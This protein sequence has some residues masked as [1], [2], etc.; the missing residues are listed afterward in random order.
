MNKLFAALTKPAKLI[1]IIGGFVYALWF[2][3]HTGLSINGGFVN[4]FSNII[5]LFV[6][7]GLLVIPPLFLLIKKEETAKLIFVFLLGFWVLTAPRE[8][9]AL[10]DGFAD[11]QEFYPVFVAIFFLLVGLGIVAILVLV[12]LQLLFGMKFLRPIINLIA[13]IVVGLSILT[14]ILFIILCA[15]NKVDWSFYVRYALMDLTVLPVTVGA[16]CL[17]FFS[18]E[19]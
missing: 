10:A 5:V 14:A 18:A 17:Y 11:A 1:F 7:V 3:I 4:V 8:F 15:I 9:F 16:G 2:G 13:L 19:K 12:V 6:G